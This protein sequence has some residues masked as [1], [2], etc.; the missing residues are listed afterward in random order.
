LIRGFSARAK[1]A[2]RDAMQVGANHRSPGG[3]DYLIQG[4]STG[5]GRSS[6]PTAHVFRNPKCQNFED[7]LPHGL[8]GGQSSTGKRALWTS[9]TGTRPGPPRNAA[10]KSPNPT[11]QDLPRLMGNSCGPTWRNPFPCPRL[12]ESIPVLPDPI[13]L[14]DLATP[15]TAAWCS[16]NPESVAA[17]YSHQGSLRDNDRTPAVGR[18]VIA[19]VAPLGSALQEIE[20][21]GEEAA[22]AARV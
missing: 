9:S 22:G 20:I 3:P 15:Y 10:M 8:T 14:R 17:F 19:R 2:W 16:Q 4:R 21:E 7:V 13:D 5:S 12:V 18:N 6:G 1:G 11:Y